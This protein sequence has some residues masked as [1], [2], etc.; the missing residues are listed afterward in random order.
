MNELL[1]QRAV[2]HRPNGGLVLKRKEIHEILKE[3]D[4]VGIAF[5]V[6]EPGSAF[7]V[8]LKVYK[9][10]KG[11]KGLEGEEREIN[12]QK[13][14]AGLEEI[15]DEANKFCFEYGS[16][17]VDSGFDFAYLPKTEFERLFSN[18]EDEVFVTGVVKDYGKLGKPKGKWFSLSATPRLNPAKEKF[19]GNL[20]KAYFMEACPPFWTPDGSDGLIG[21]EVILLKK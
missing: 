12:H 3:E 20:P 5:G 2:N 8:K 15:E 19:L 16:Q 18:G 10:T 17:L 9:V 14:A 6:E 1:K 11:E 13:G 21:G 4:S 7:N